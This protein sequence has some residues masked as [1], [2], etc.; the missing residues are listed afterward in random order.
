M[1]TIALLEHFPGLGTRQSTPGVLKL[2][3]RNYPYLVFYVVIAHADEVSIVTIQ[4]ASR[5][6]EFQDA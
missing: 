1:Q 2:V 6:R 4:H 5:E 3:V